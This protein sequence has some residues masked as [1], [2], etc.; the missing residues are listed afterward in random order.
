[1]TPFRATE[2]G[3]VRRVVAG[4]AAGLFATGI[5]SGV[6]LAAQ[7]LS[8]LGRLPPRMIVER[9]APG[10]DEATAKP[11]ATIA[12]FAYGASAGAVFGLL[13]RRAKGGGVRGVAWG[14]ALW[15]AGYEGWLPA[16]RILPMAHDDD[17]RRAGSILTAHLV[18]GLVLGSI[19]R[20]AL[21]R[22][23]RVRI[24]RRGVRGRS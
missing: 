5:M 17:R 7:R 20:R 21:V 22:V 18:Y 9:L 24:P 2:A 3:A 19:Y 10:V 15:A 14:C 6:F 8:L 13:A 4:T 12:H 11:L 16:M 23:Q 1:M